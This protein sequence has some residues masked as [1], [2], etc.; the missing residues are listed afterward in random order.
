MRKKLCAEDPLNGE[1][2]LCGNSFDA[3]DD[4]MCETD[5]FDFARLGQTVT[6]TECLRAI[7]KIKA[8]YSPKGR[9]YK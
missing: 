6:C 1:F 4:P 9:Y 3:P 7:A 5:P 8:R 2:S